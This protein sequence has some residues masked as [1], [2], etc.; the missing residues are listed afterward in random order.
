VKKLSINELCLLDKVFDEALSTL[1]PQQKDFDD[2][3]E[4][5][6]KVT[7][8]FYYSPPESKEK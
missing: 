3:I 1:T 7:A 4:L 5:R 6:K 8:N 2:I